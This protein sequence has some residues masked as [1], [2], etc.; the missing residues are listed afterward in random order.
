MS[1][2]KESQSSTPT[3]TE[4]T[5][6]PVIKKTG[7]S[8]KIPTTVRPGAAKVDQAGQVKS[9]DHKTK[10]S[11]SLS[12][13][14]SLLKSSSTTTVQEALI[15]IRKR[16]IKQKDGIQRLRR[17]GGLQDLVN[18]VQQGSNQQLTDAAL[19]ILGNCCTEEKSCKQVC[20]DL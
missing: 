11:H 10:L 2:Q 16:F 9:A 3:P 20:V 15:L 17:Y 6:K 5:P 12:H 13:T 1:S 18:I 14:V 4:S 8:T 7:V 19:S